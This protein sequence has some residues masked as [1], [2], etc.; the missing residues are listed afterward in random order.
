MG[1]G[2]VLEL[3][4]PPPTPAPVGPQ[5]LH[6]G[7]REGLTSADLG[8]PSQS[9]VLNL[10]NPTGPRLVVVVLRGGVGRWGGVG[11]VVSWGGVGRQVAIGTG[12][13]GC[14]G[15]SGLA[16]CPETGLVTLDTGAR[17]GDGDLG[18]VRSAL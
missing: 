13:Q 8:G 15:L 14:P 17:E 4:V 3:Q 10:K 2:R 1:W 9:D 7:Q 5:F 16:S 18:M 12:A 11:G 6:L